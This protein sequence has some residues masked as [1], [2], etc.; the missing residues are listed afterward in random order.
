MATIEIAFFAGDHQKAIEQVRHTVFVTGLQIDAAL[1]F[2]GQDPEAIHVL[3]W[4]ED[5][6]VGTGRLLRDGRV[7]RM[8]VLEEYRNRGIGTEMLRTLIDQ[9][10]MLAMPRIH[11]GSQLDAVALYRRAGFQ[12]Y[13]E[14]YEE[15]GIP[16][17]TMDL[18]LKPE[19]RARELGHVLWK[20]H[21]LDQP[22]AE[23]DCILVFCSNDPRVAERGADLFLSGWAPLLVF[24][25]HEGELTRG[26][27][28]KPEAE[29][30][31]D[32]ALERGVPLANI[33]T[34]TKATNTGENIHFT[35]ELLR[36]SG[37]EPQNILLV[38][39]PYME[40]RAWASFRK[41]WPEVHVQ[42]TSPESTFSEYPTEALPLE[43]VI[44]IMV[45]DLQRIRDYPARGFQVEQEI[46][47]EVQSAY[48]ELIRL[49]YDQHLIDE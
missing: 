7:G 9:A 5:R 27:Y 41:A 24:S 30:F 2:D 28:G 26:M 12:S 3:A 15:I 25:G 19:Q 23:A 45:G 17:V 37:M 46:P 38:Q 32:I 18:V 49:G 6:P 42:V 29:F 11:L 36:Q 34:E 14:I 39:K 35:R 10:R 47:D 13:G 22:L 20:Y 21:Q 40:R 44:N 31:A 43:R 16:H 8:A 48:E 33:L 1:E 4:E